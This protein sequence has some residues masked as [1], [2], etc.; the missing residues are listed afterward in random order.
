MKRFVPLSL[1]AGAAFVCLSGVGQA[2][3]LTGA[4]GQGVASAHASGIVSKARWY[5]HHHYRHR[6]CWW[7]HHRRHCRYWW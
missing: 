4:E 6:R 3:P 2:A 5:R 1:V 7:H